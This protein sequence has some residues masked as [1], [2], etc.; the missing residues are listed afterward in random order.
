MAT[1]PSSSKKVNLWYMRHAA[2]EMLIDMDE[3]GLIC[4]VPSE[5]DLEKS[6]V[7]HVDEITVLV[8]VATSCECRAFEMHKTCKHCT[9]VNVYY[10]RIYRSSIAKAQAKAAVQQVVETPATAVVVVEEKPVVAEK[11]AMQ[12]DKNIYF[13]QER[14]CYCYRMTNRPVD[15]GYASNVNGSRGFHPLRAG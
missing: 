5:N 12:E 10:K 9:I 3:Q 7:V 1:R 2:S 11:P 15:A 6:Y 13:D 8:P 4:I 14:G